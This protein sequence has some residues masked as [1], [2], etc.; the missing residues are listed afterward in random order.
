M[1]GPR[2]GLP[3]F[4]A[5][6]D[7]ERG[8]DPLDLA[9]TLGPESGLILRHFGRADQM[10]L[11]APLSALAQRRGFLLLIAADPVLAQ[12]VG[13]HGVHW[14]ERLW[15]AAAH[16]RLKRPDW[17]VTAAAHNARSLFRLAGRAHAAL[18][19]PVFDSASPSAGR[20]LGPRRAAGL[21][22]AAPTPVYAL[23]G[24]TARRARRLQGLGFSGAA[25]V[26]ARM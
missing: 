20:P 18:L 2:D 23:G 26:S 5:L 8:P 11:A 4:F 16:W 24:L 17:V 14:P 7:P 12:R 13:A 3:A 1:E 6:T 9:Q 15:P 19:S 21:A 10:T 22:M 25:A